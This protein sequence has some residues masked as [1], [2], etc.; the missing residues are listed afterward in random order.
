MKC[1]LA[2]L[3]V[4]NNE[5]QLKIEKDINKK[6]YDLIKECSEIL[7]SFNMFCDYF[8]MLDLNMNEII[9]YINKIKLDSFKISNPIIK[10]KIF[11]ELN[12]LM[13]NFSGM[14]RTFLAYHE[15]FI[16]EI[17]VDEE[18]GDEAKELSD[19]KKSCSKKFDDFFEYRFLYNIRHYTVK[20]K[21]LITKMIYNAEVKNKHFYFDVD[22]L[23]KWSGWK[24]NI[25]ADIQNLKKDINVEDFMNEVKKILAEFKKDI[26]FISKFEVIGA[27]NILDKYRR[28]NSTPYIIIPKDDNVAMEIQPL[29][30]EQIVAKANI[31]K[32]GFASMSIWDK[33]KGFVLYDPYNL[34]FTKEQKEKLGFK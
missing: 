8:D 26:S 32:L 5:K 14:F 10:H 25:K 15:R 12:R 34:T 13:T 33:E 28:P 22:A 9:N 29:F 16:K 24:A 31:K 23:K 1:Q 2:Y 11:V 4:E 6:E 20:Y 7:S 17:Y 19:F 3:T 27:I 21:P 30:D 18:N